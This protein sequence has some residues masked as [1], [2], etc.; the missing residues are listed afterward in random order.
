MFLFGCWEIED[1]D[2]KIFETLYSMLFI[3][4]TKGEQITLELVEDNSMELGFSSF[5]FI[6]NFFGS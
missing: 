4:K 5:I 1:K 3:K 6:G 2:Y